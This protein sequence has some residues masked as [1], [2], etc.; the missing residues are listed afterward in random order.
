MITLSWND[1]ELTSS[2]VRGH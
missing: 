1:N 2:T